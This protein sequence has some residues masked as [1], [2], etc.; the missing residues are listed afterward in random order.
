MKDKFDDGAYL[1][2]QHIQKPVFIRDRVCI[3]AVYDAIE[4]A[5]EDVI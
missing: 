5:K 4:L 3:L 2:Y 1:M